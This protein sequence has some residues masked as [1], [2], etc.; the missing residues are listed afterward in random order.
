MGNI[1]SNKGKQCEVAERIFS[2]CFD[3]LGLLIE[4]WRRQSCQ[5]NKSL[6]PERVAAFFHVYSAVDVNADKWPAPRCPSPGFRR[7]NWRIE[8]DRRSWCNQNWL[9]K[10]P[11]RTVVHL[12]QSFT[13]CLRVIVIHSTKCNAERSRF[14]NASLCDFIWYGLKITVDRQL[15]FVSIM[16]ATKHYSKT[17]PHD[18]LIFYYIS[19]RYE[20]N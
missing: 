1:I 5:K 6:A 10:K 13:F 8:T 2:Y 14:K 4:C 15:W 7:N 12:N 20:H 9:I 17:H 3:S 11:Q 18:I 16:R 19:H